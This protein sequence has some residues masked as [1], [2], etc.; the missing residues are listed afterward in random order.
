MRLTLIAAALALA[1]CATTNYELQ[2]MPRDSGKLYSGTAENVGYGEGRVAVTIEGKE[3]RGTWVAMTP[4]NTN[5]YV[6]G[7]IGYG[8]GR[9]GYGWGGLGLGTVISIENPAGGESMA[10]LNAADGSGLRCE[11]RASQGFGGGWCR[12]D[13][14][15]N[16]DVQLRP[17]PRG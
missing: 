1:G 6:S 17:L 3:Y 10:L 7:G 5:A 14:G 12:D 9:Y 8:R 4:S 11:F 13:S 16:Y 15:R 2:V